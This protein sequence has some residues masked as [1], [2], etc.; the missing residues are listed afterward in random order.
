DARSLARAI[1]DVA[2][3]AGLR[4]TALLTDMSQVLGRNAGNA[5]EVA[6]CIEALVTGRGEA[7]LLVVT[8]ALAAEMLVITGLAPAE[9]A[10]GRVDRA[11]ASG[12]AAERSQRMV[13]GLGGPADILTRWRDHLPAAPIRRAALP[14]RPGTVLGVDT[15]AAGLAVLDLGG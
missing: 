13:A 10:P 7:R 9:E 15:R 12:E 3:D 4:T 11:L 2:N 6:E 1:V 8:K 14:E 5:L